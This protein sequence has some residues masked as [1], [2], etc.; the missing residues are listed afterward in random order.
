M[1]IQNSWKGS[2]TQ[3]HSLKAKISSNICHCRFFREKD[4]CLQGKS[5]PAFVKKFRFRSTQKSLLV[6]LDSL[7]AK[8]DSWPNL[9]L[10]QPRLNCFENT[11]RTKIVLNLKSRSF[12]VFQREFR[13]LIALTSAVRRWKTQ[14]SAQMWHWCE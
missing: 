7:F 8:G 9:K 12:E 2:F 13:Y 6:I 4:H 3:K 1:T 14:N 11:K 5:E 10:I